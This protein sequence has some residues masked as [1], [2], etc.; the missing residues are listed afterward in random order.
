MFLCKGSVWLCT[1]FFS[2]SNYALVC[3]FTKFQFKQSLSLALYKILFHA[4]VLY[5]MESQ[6]CKHCKRFAI[7]AMVFG[8]VA[9]LFFLRNCVIFL[10]KCCIIFLLRGYM[11][12]FVERLR[13][14]DVVKRLRDF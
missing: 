7:L 5:K 2:S 13:D 12:F 1:Q 14:F 3:L 4:K 8:K 11:T 6:T 10:L 9:R